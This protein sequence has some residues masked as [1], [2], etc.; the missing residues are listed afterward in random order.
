MSILRAFKNRIRWSLAKFLEPEIDGLITHRIL[1]FRQK[2]AA[3]GHIKLAPRTEMHS[4]HER[5]VALFGRSH[6]SEHK[7]KS[8]CPDI[9]Q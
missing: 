4:D 5:L 6:L 1:L 3:D 7:T 9:P 8:L 2:L